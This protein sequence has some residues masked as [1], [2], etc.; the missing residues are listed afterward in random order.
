MKQ[1][2]VYFNIFVFRDSSYVQT[3]VD[4]GLQVGA[5]ALTPA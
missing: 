2:E 4:K 1:Q 3:V 5:F